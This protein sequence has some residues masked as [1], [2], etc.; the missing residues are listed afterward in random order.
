MRS[1]ALIHR[2]RVIDTMEVDDDTRPARSDLA[3]AYWVEVTNVSPAPARGQ[4]YDG[5]SFSDP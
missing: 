3:G 1:F 4:A 5:F 2:E